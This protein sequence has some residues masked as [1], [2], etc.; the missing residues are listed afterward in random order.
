MHGFGVA[1]FDIGLPNLLSIVT[2]HLNPFASDLA[3]GEVGL[4]TTRAYRYGPFAIIG[5][6][7]NYPP[8][9]GPEP[10]YTAQKPYNT[11]ART[12]LNDPSNNEP[13]QPD[14]RISWKLEQAGF[15]DVAYHMYQKT[16]DEKF[17][18]R[19]AN[20][21][22]IDQFWVSKPLADRL[23]NYWV[24]GNPE[25]AS[26]HKGIVFQLDTDKVNASDNWNYI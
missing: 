22:R 21:D 4:I 9:R 5:G 25:G 23:I 17:L 13:L 3:L 14:R 18:E 24:V 11:A 16:K 12:V 20:E 10:N 8:S 7:I 6:D 2:T 26:D 1:A 15:V 19:T